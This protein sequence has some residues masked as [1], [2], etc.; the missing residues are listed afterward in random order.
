MYARQGF[1]I[2]EQ[3][4]GDVARLT[5]KQARFVAEYL[6]DMNAT[7]AAKRAGY[8]EKTAY[9]IGFENLRKPEIQEAVQVAMADRAKRTEITQD[10]VIRELAKVA[11]SNGTDFAR[12]ISTPSVTTVVGENGEI[13]QVIRPIQHVELVDTEKISPDKRAAIASIKEGKFGIE[14]KGYDK[15]KA[16]ELLGQH[17]GMFSG[18][19]VQ[20]DDNHSLD[21][22]FID[23][24]REE[25]ADVWQE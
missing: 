7:E 8:S 1:F 6:V 9:S 25:A 16:L 3:R 14:V 2:L 12:I 10:M 17:L 23:A 5:E 4:G 24:L 21:D 15:I 20:N 22:G 18:K 19:E 13:Q 11:F